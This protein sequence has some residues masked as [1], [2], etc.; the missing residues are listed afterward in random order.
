MS[1]LKRN[2]YLLTKNKNANMNISLLNKDYTFKL[3]QDNKENFQMNNMTNNMTNNMGTIVYNN[4]I[5]KFAYGS[6]FYYKQPEMDNNTR[7]LIQMSDNLVGQK[8]L[9]EGPVD[10]II[11][12]SNYN[13]M[14]NN[15]NP[16][17]VNMNHNL[18]NNI[19]TN[20]HNSNFPKKNSSVFNYY[21]NV[22]YVNPNTGNT[23]QNQQGRLIRN[24]NQNTSNVAYNES[25]NKFNNEYQNKTNQQNV[26]YSEISNHP[27][28]NS[29][30]QVEGQNLVSQI[31]QSQVNQ[32]QISQGQANQD[33][34]SQG[35]PQIGDYFANL[36]QDPNKLVN[37][38]DNQTNIKSTT[39]KKVKLNTVEID[40]YGEL[41]YAQLYNEY[42]GTEH[43]K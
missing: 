42:D 23:N 41:L 32:G 40:Y 21:S 35:Q 10:R 11:R 26:N 24:F 2:Q 9:N 38:I 16:S 22:N 20:Y 15:V 39:K 19:E 37:P 1:R 7:Q 8:D 43:F 18:N 29:V 3:D 34:T 25:Y 12:P 17:E 4:P 31:S 6:C 33:Q 14:R 27:G 13:K 5:N 36:V 28:D 30:K